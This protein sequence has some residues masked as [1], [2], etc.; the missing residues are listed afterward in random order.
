MWVGRGS[1]YNTMWRQSYEGNLHHAR[2]DLLGMV[3]LDRGDLALLSQQL[4]SRTGERGVDLQTLNQ[5]GRRDELHLGHLS[6]E[7]VPAILIEEDLGVQL[8]SELTLVP[9]LLNEQKI[10]N[11]ETSIKYR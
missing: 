7:T 3:Q 8:L 5:G 9:L 2:V 11:A 1:I 4:A 10:N 6:L